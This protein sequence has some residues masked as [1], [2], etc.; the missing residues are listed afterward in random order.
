MLS[1]SDAHRE[2][3]ALA[4]EFAAN[5]I[6]PHAAD[7][8]ARGHVPVD[9]IRRMGGLGLLAPAIP[10][11]Y[12]GPGLDATALCLI[13]EEIARADAGTS[14]S[15]AVQNGL[16]ASPLL[17]AGTAEQKETWLPPLASGE[18]MGC[19][20]LTE[21]GVGSDTA[22]L[23]TRATPAGDGWAITGAKQWISNGGFADLFI[24]FARSG[25]DGARGISAFITGR[26]DGLTVG[27]EIPKLGLHSS[28]TVELAFDDMHVG[29][30]ALLGA[31]GEGLKLAL[32]TLD[33]GRITVA[34]Q[35]CG[36]AR[37]ALDVAVEYATG[38]EAFGGPIARFQG[39]QFPIADIAAQLDAARLL[40]LHAAAL[41]DAG[42]PH[43][44]AGAKAKL[45]ASSVAVRAADVAVQT[46]GGYGYSAEYDAERLYR[47][48]KITEI[49]EG[50]S[51]IQRLV[52]GRD[53]FGDAAR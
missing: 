37:A 28:S 38:R 35:A 43:G 34:A 36:I 40:T 5:E 29:P 33:G 41:R 10:E 46:L 16:V 9:V 26:A 23:T 1:L 27:A 51:Q 53:L 3:Q 6:A 52:I 21:P 50:T 48:A 17:R 13:V 32:A 15:I 14:V 12:G 30:D 44:V 42:E 19:Y 11:Q 4:R 7:W 22:A 47:D 24:V 18:V 2:V 45:F 39:V 8:D 25:G 20:A 49:Y 31:E